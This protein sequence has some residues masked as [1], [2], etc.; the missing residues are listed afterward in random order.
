[1]AKLVGVYE[2]EAAVR[3]GRRQLPLSVYDNKIMTMQLGES[4]D[5]CDFPGG[6]TKRRCDDSFTRQ[7]NA[8]SK[9]EVVAALMVPSKVLFTRLA[10]TVAC[11]G[12][13]RR[14]LKP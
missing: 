13:R 12:C 11:V 4:C 9:E 10:Q 3:L 5:G 6:T 7:Y 8:L 1:M 2:D 14:L